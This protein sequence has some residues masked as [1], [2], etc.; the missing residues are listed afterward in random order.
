MERSNYKTNGLNVTLIK[1]DKFKTVDLVL[2]FRNYLRKETVTSKALVPYVLKSATEKYGNKREINRKLE[3]LYGANLGISINKQG[4]LQVISFRISIV[5]DIYL[6]NESSLIDDAFA[7]LHEIIFN[8]KLENG[9]FTEKVVLEEKRLLKDQFISLYNDKIRYAYNKLIEEMCKDEIYRFRALGQMEDLDNITNESLFNVYKDL[10]KNDTVDLLVTGDIDEN[11]IKKLIENNLKFEDRTD[12][13]EVVDKESK[14]ISKVK[15]TFEYQDVSQAKINI[16]FR[17]N[18]TG[19]DKDYYP[20]LLMNAML[21]VYPHSL[22][23]QNVREK[24]SLCYYIASNIDKAKGIMVIYAG[25][26]KDDYDKAHDLILEQIRKLQVG[27]I[28]EKLLLNSSK[29]LVN[30]LLEIGDNP[31]G[32]L[33]SNYSHLLYQ[34]E[35]DIDLITKKINEVTKEEIQNVAKKIKEDTIFF[36]AKEEVKE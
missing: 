16:G 36:L 22:L 30:D 15:K 34:E 17:T 14:E 2:N 33:A 21:G 6:S 13:N 28:D 5:N 8:P 3:K 12:I 10:L 27:E 32:I 25:I 23:F 19:L 11:R 18:T 35:F 20:L 24:A 4:I 7:F 9:V 26:N 31:I 1:T 29:A